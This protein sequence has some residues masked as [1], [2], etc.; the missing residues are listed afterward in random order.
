MIRHAEI[1]DAELLR[2]IMFENDK[3]HSDGRP[4]LFNPAEKKSREDIISLIKSDDKEFF[5]YEKNETV[6]GYV[7][8]EIQIILKDEHSRGEERI[9]I[10][11]LCVSHESRHE[12]IATE[13]FNYVTD[14]ARNNG[15]YN[16]ILCC[17]EFNGIARKFYEKLGMKPQRTI[18]EMI[19]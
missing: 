17:W 8:F 6:V 3:L 10:K 11:N 12:G 14:F 13:L 16:V 9:Y 1:K 18:M 4:D 5:V 2:D 19:L 15:C 7:I